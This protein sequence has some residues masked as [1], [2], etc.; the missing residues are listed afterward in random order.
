MFTDSQV[1]QFIKDEKVFIGHDLEVI[2]RDRVTGAA[3][4]SIGLIGGTKDE[5]RRVPNGTV[6]E[7]NV[8]AEVGGDPSNNAESFSNQVEAVMGDLTAIIPSHLMGCFDSS[9]EFPD[10]E[11]QHPDAF[12]IG[13]DPDFDAYSL[14]TNDPGAY[15]LKKNEPGEYAGPLRAA[16]GHIHLSWGS[17]G[18]NLTG[19]RRAQLKQ[20]ADQ[21]VLITKAH[22]LLVSIPEILISPDLRRK[23]HYGKAGSMRA[24][25]YGLEVRTPSN[26]WG[27]T[28]T[29]RKWAFG[30]SVRALMVKELPIPEEILVKCINTCDQDLAQEIVET[31]NIPMPVGW[32]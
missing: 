30:N 31:Y 10:S 25:P 17:F 12:K 29:L 3:V 7:D 13:C 4:S 11:L 16:G 9:E 28:D 22:D 8:L 1:S 27:K 15:K 19:S 5:P 32:K 14:D 26:F 18:K 6:Q 23:Q 2:L 20:L 21:R 24:K